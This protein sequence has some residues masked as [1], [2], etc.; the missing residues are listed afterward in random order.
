MVSFRVSQRKMLRVIRTD[1]PNLPTLSLIL[2]G[3][4][5][6]FDRPSADQEGLRPHDLSE[7]NTDAG[8][9]A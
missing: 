3:V 4:L 6:L 2:Y 5:G 1:G 7:S 8:L 9:K